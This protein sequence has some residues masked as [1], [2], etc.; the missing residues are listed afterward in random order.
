MALLKTKLAALRIPVVANPS[1][2]VPVLVG[3]A[4]TAK[5]ISD[6]LL[7]KYKIYVQS[8]NFPTVAVGTERLRITPTPWHDESQCDVLCAALDKIWTERGLK[9]L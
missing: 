3:D 9:R 8:I 5:S 6:E 2:I 4:S 1:H 7:T